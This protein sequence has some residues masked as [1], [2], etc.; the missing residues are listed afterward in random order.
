MEA[1]N[2][3]A[4]SGSMLISMFFSFVTLALRSSMRS[5]TQAAKSSPTMLYAMLTKNY[6]GSFFTSRSTGRK[7]STS[8]I[9]AISA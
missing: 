1:W 2:A 9:L 8:G 5:F 6:L 3:A 4:T 7:V